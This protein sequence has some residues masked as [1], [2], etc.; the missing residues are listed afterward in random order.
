MTL[1]SSGPISIGGSTAGQSIN[2]ELNR[3]AGAT[4]SLNEE[5]LRA[6]AG[7][8][9]GQISLSSFYGKSNYLGN[10]ITTSLGFT[11]AGIMKVI[12]IV[13]NYTEYLLL[14]R[15][16]PST[17]TYHIVKIDDLGNKV[18]E[19]Q[20]T[21]GFAGYADLSDVTATY[22]TGNYEDIYATYL[23][24]GYSSAFGTNIGTLHLVHFE[25]INNTVL[26][27]ASNS[28]SV[29]NM[30]LDL[31]NPNINMPVA[32]G[33][34][35]YVSANYILIV[36][37]IR[38]T[39]AQT[40][41]IWFYRV[42]KDTKDFIKFTM[43]VGPGAGYAN[44]FA[45]WGYIDVLSFYVSRNNNDVYIPVGSGVFKFDLGSLTGGTN[46]GTYITLSDGKFI[47]FNSDSTSEYCIWTRYGYDTTPNYVQENIFKF[48]KSTYATTHLLKITDA[49]NGGGS[50]YLESKSTTG[51][52]G[53]TPV[54]NA[55]GSRSLAMINGACFY[56]I[57]TWGSNSYAT[58]Y[59]SVYNYLRFSDNYTSLTKSK[60]LNI[61]FS[62]G[63]ASDN[64]LRFGSNI[65]PSYNNQGLRTDQTLMFTSNT[66]ITYLHGYGNNYNGQRVFDS[67]L[68]KVSLDL[69]SVN[70]TFNVTVGG[71][72]RTVVFEM[73]DG[74]FNLL[75]N[76]VPLPSTM[77]TSSKQIFLDGAFAYT[78]NYYDSTI[79][80]SIATSAVITLPTAVKVQL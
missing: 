11:E 38:N 68:T 36:S 27:P 48:N 53:P 40:S 32:T 56:P 61:Y 43:Q 41:T 39:T 20:I 19:R 7:I 26:N 74:S 79:N 16:N 18:Y 55:G 78:T 23:L 33:A 51:P 59:G 63:T 8:A 50:P 1:N 14:I 17:T 70:K 2:L 21:T 24:Q 77:T 71:T 5:A 72:P 10:Y 80:F 67:M 66:S 73:V 6:L 75:S 62:G 37:E 15:S 52:T 64:T 47:P 65:Y 45:D 34:N 28:Y 13:G 49:A 58:T 12:K 44:T 35:I 9:S 31:Y 57:S 60:I 29:N 69:P 22:H 46:T 3:A 76:S 30:S 25:P 42:N 4:S 54:M